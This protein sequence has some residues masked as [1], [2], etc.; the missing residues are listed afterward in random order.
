MLMSGLLGW[1]KKHGVKLIVS[2]VLIALQGT[3]QCES[4]QS[5]IYVSDS[6]YTK[7]QIYI[8]TNRN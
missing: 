8:I 7:Y 6:S 4:Q 3:S 2:H 5:F 1:R